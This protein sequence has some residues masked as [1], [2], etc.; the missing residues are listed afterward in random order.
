[1]A[2]NDAA[3]AR[4]ALETLRLRILDLGRNCIKEITPELV[5]AAQDAVDEELR[6]G[7]GPNKKAFA[8]RADGTPAEMGSLGRQIA[9]SQ[10]GTDTVTVAGNSPYIRANMVAASRRIRGGGYKKLAAPGRP[11]LPYPGQLPLL[12]SKL[13]RAALTRVLRKQRQ[14]LSEPLK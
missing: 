9:I 8:P 14:K 1:M 13:L 3:N 2:R 10:S 5:K 4:R 11:L 12:W 6:S 7:V